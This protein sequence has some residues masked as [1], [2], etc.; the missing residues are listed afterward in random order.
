[1]KVRINIEALKNTVANMD[2]IMKGN[3]VSML[4][5]LLMTAEDAGITVTVNNLNIMVSKRI[6]GD[7]LT[8]GKAL[9]HRDDLA[10]LLKMKGDVE[11][12]FNGNQCIVTGSRIFKFET[13]GGAEDYPSLPDV[14]SND[15]NFT[16]PEDELFYCMK[17]KKLI[18]EPSE[19]P[20]LCGIWIEANNVL[21]CDGF[22]LGK[23]EVTSHASKMFMLPDFVLNYLTKALDKK[24]TAPVT[25]YL[26]EKGYVRACSES[27]EITYRQYE[28]EFVQYKTLFDLS[29]VKIAVIRKQD[30]SSSVGFMCDVYKSS[31]KG[32][33]RRKDPIVYA[34][35]ADRLKLALDANGK[36]VEEEIEVEQL[37]GDIDFEIGFQPVQHYELLSLIDGNELTMSFEGP[38]SHSVIYGAKENEKYLM[39]PLSTKKAA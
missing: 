33:S 21:A 8:K 10:M 35:N 39:I 34:F 28:G 9:L 25:F 1:M 27:V 14:L 11:L 4:D 32:K 17:L 2:S 15:S 18:A 30:L 5:C 29:R 20:R 13:V 38:L 23:I 24:S 36:Y 16:I 7:V 12:V 19:R 6:P 3:K 31:Y 22:R 26:S 37:S